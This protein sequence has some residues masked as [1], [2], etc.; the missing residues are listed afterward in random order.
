ML[1]FTSCAAGGRALASNMASPKPPVSRREGLAAEASRPSSLDGELSRVSYL[2]NQAGVAVWSITPPE[3]PHNA[4]AN[5]VAAQPSRLHTS[6]SSDGSAS[7][8]VSSGVEAADK[9][10]GA[11]TGAPA[12]STDS[13]AELTFGETLSELL[14]QD[15]STSHEKLHIKLG[16]ALTHAG[17]CFCDSPRAPD[18]RSPLPAGG[19]S[20][21][22][23]L[24]A[25]TAVVSGA[26]LARRVA[27]EHSRK[28]VADA[29]TASAEI[30]SLESLSD[31][32]VLA[33]VRRA[34]QCKKAAE[35][36]AREALYAPAF[37]HGDVDGGRL[38]AHIRQ[39]LLGDAPALRDT[40]VP[41]AVAQRALV[42]AVRRRGKR[43]SAMSAIKQ[44]A[45]ARPPS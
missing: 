2:L 41:P 17:S 42:A 23:L 21:L 25:A 45:P 44:Y 13:A 8:V 24:F 38:P 30:K 10:G 36:H 15:A 14:T 22:R 40:V 37:L 7:T 11:R 43:T 16:A 26:L 39:K 31:A 27:T 6:S 12:G 29:Q 3:S 19:G 28:R 18:K 33:L 35:T 4:A 34:E 5:S 1:C 9:V 20:P 32:Q